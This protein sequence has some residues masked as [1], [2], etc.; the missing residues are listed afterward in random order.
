V[1]DFFE[2]PPPREPEPIPEQPPWL[3]PPENE[4]GVPVPLRLLLART[5]DVAVALLDVSAFSTGLQFRMEVRLRAH[6]ELIDPFGMR[7]R[8]TRRGGAAE[9]PDDVLRFG[10]E[11]ADGSRVTNLGDFPAFEGERTAPVLIQ[12]GGG[13]GGRAWSFGYWL[14]PL[15]PPGPLTAVVE[16]PSRRIEVTRVELDAGPI[17]TAAA[18][19]AP[20]W[21]DGGARSGG[22]WTGYGPVA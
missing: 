12:R 18:E 1:S 5:D 19:S 15:P 20:F 9:L 21:P 4:V 14:W 10:F 8:H 3:G 7:L 16:W 22:G 11:L 2:P 17:L 6:D 13:G